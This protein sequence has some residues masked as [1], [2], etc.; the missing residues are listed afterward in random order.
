ML[1]GLSTPEIIQWFRMVQQGAPEAVWMNLKGIARTA[2]PAAVL[3][4][5]EVAASRSHMTVV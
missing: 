1:K 4:D 3:F 5:I 2:L